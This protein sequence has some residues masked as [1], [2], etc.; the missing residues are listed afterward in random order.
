MKKFMSGSLALVA[1]MAAVASASAA[2]L[3]AR[4]YAKA[5]SVVDP[6]FNWSGFYLGAHARLWAG[7]VRIM[8]TGSRRMVDLRSRRPIRRRAELRPAPLR[9]PGWLQLAG[10]KLGVR[11]RIGRQWHQHQSHRHQPLLSSLPIAER[12][13]RGTFTASG[14]LGYAFNNWLPTSRAVMP[15]RSSTSAILDCSVAVW[16]STSAERLRPRCRPRI[17]IHHPTGRSVSNTTTFSACRNLP[18]NSFTALSE[19]A[20]SNA[21][22]IK[23]RTSTWSPLASTTASAARSSRSTDPL[24]HIWLRKAGLAPAFLFVGHCQLLPLT[25]FHHANRFPLRLKTLMQATN[26]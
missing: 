5:P 12:Q 7:P 26:R 19:S 18:N 14:R 11:H 13:G 21:S 6:T 25:R 16:K 20:P 9:R 4:P 1:L 2:D 24:F 22:T 15:A 17:R 10:R 23:L 8:P 3:A